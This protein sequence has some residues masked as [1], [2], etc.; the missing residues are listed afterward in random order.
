MPAVLPTALQVI[1]AATGMVSGGVA[2]D[3]DAR[4]VF[5]I[6]INNLGAL[7]EGRGV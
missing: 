4:Q 7:N 3:A 5:E 1:L 6:S 2:G